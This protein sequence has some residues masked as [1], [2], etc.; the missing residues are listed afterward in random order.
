MNITRIT[1]LI[2]TGSTDYVVVQTTLPSPFPSTVSDQPLTM[3]FEVSA[4][5]G[6]EYVLANFLGMPV[7]TLDHKTG[8]EVQVRL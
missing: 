6:L 1:I 7:W 2:H 8:A 3:K 4:G 5:K